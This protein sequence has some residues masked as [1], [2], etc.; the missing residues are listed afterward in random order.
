MIDNIF[1]NNTEFETLSGNILTQIADHFPQIMILKKV[2]PNLKECS[3]ASYDYSG[4]N[5]QT[6]IDDY[7]GVKLDLERNEDVNMMFRKFLILS[8]TVLSA[9]FPSKDEQK[10]LLNSKPSPGSQ[11]VFKNLL[12]IMIGY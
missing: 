7:T 12:L 3:F 1:S 6:F 8:Q 4:V 2:C 9:M 11:L 10:N 5:Q